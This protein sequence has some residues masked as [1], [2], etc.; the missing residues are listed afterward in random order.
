MDDW[1]IK[2]RRAAKTAT[3]QWGR[4]N[5]DNYKWTQR[6]DRV[7]IYGKRK[8]GSSM[9]GENI[10][11]V[12][13][14]ELLNEQDFRCAITGTPLTPSYSSIDHINPSS[15]GGANSKANCHWVC[16]EINQMK[17]GMSLSEFYR[18]CRI[19]VEGGNGSNS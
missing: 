15:E 2:I 5:H 18:W 11:R 1:T 12:E 19:A 16:P 8:A 13:L 9:V 10:S 6:I 7:H 14:R 4:R 3:I 17:G